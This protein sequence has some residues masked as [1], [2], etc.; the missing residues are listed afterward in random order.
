MPRL[1]SV[2][3]A[4]LLLSFA[5]CA[6]AEDPAPKEIVPLVV[7]NRW[8]YRRTETDRRTGRT[9]PDETDKAAVHEKR[10]IG[11]KTWFRYT[12]F[13]D[14]FWVRSGPDGQSE[15]RDFDEEGD[16]DPNSGAVFYRYPV[17]KVPLEY[18]VG[19]SKI[20]VVATD[21]VVTTPAGR[22]TCYVY[23]LVEPGLVVEMSVA[24]GVGLVKHRFDLKDSN[25]V[26]A[27]LVKFTPAKRTG[28][29]KDE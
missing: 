21:R 28:S 17:A 15:L 3:V 27:E 14:E 1:P 8:E 7:G 25:L 6:L 23:R 2:H 18:E 9:F 4:L 12:E 26:V 22:F 24:P 13:D 20:T 10:V 29:E 19:G 11:G 5:T 16:P